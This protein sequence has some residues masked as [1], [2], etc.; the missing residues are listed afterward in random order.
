MNSNSKRNKFI[1]LFLIICLSI[2]VFLIGKSNFKESRIEF[3]Y[4]DA[5]QSIDY[6]DITYIIGHKNPDS[7]TVISA[8]TY[9]SLKEQLGVNC[10]PM[11]SG[12]INNE[13][14][15]ILER[16]NVTVPQIMEDAG[17]NN[18]ILV[19]HSSFSQAINGMENANIVEIIDH[20]GLGGIQTANPIYIKDLPIGATATIIYSSYIENNIDIDETTAGLLLSAILSDTGGLTYSTTTKVDIDACNYL[21]S[22]AKINDINDYY[23]VLIDYASSYDGMNDEEIFYSDYKEY[24]M[25]G[26]NVGITCI[27][28]NDENEDVMCERMK[29]FMQNNYDNQEM[30]HLFILFNNAYSNNSK[31]IYYGE[32]TKEIAIKAFNDHTNDYIEFN[33]ILSR[34]KDVVP[35]LEKAYKDK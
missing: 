24:E 6:G 32:G 2:V 30:K 11:I 25:S 27:N 31:I 17:N 15:Y 3:N 35:L 8:I 22:I 13:T 29:I 14:K 4:S 12:K 26:I 19:D 34:K 7:D 9:A 5:V 23:N 16:F 18:I 28:V 10:K 20:H 1:V 33:S 21:A